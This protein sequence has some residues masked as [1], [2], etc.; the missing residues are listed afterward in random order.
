VGDGGGC[1][2]HQEKE[3]MKVPEDAV[4]QGVALLQA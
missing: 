4:R 1:V 3:V 2:A